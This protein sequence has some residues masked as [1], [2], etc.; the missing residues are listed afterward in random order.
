MPR[1]DFDDG[2]MGGSA[3]SPESMNKGSCHQSTRG[4]IKDGRGNANDVNGFVEEK[5]AQHAEYP[6]GERRHGE[7]RPKEHRHKEHRPKE[8][9]ENGPKEH[10]H[11]E[12]RPKEH[13]ENGPKEHQHKEHRSKEHEHEEN[14][15]K[16]HRHKEH[17]PK[18]HEENGPKEHQ[19]KEH[20]SKE[21]EHEENRHKEHRHKEHGPK[22][23]EHEEKGQKEH[24]HKEHRSKEHGHEENRHKEHRH[25]EHRSKEHE[26]EEHRQKEHRQKEHRPK[27]HEHEENGQKEHRHK[28]HGRDEQGHDEHRTKEHRPKEP[29]EHRHKEHGRDEHGHDKHRTKEHRHKEHR[30]GEP[31]DGKHQQKERDKGRQ[32]TEDAMTKFSKKLYKSALTHFR[33]NSGSSYPCTQSEIDFHHHGVFEKPNKGPFVT[34]IQATEEVVRWNDAKRAPP[35][36]ELATIRKLAIAVHDAEKNLLFGPDLAIK[37]FADLDRVFFGGRLRGHVAVRW[38]KM[39]DPDGRVGE[40]AHCKTGQ[41][42]IR[43][44]AGEIFTRKWREIGKNPVAIT[45][46]TLLHEMCHAYDMVRCPQEAWRGD[47]HDELFGTK[48]SVV[49]DRATHILGT[50]AIR[51]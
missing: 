33:E 39:V 23:H 49:H 13:E 46:G 15:P 16:E 19:H 40:A 20:R 27:E 48:I 50:W 42:H 24:Q 11:K 43:L 25:K 12:H 44:S 18:E 1:H 7:H 32:K 4:G 30:Q 26:H 6:Q 21:H 36:E 29:K 45:F 10:R 5:K 47:C 22:E 37:A 31:S 9:E 17:R 3:D 41:C 38:V 8:H 28:E 34:A 35:R 2:G 51:V 14:G